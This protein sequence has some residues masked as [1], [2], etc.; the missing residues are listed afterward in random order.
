MIE[1]QEL[2]EFAQVARQLARMK[3]PIAIKVN[4]ISPQGLLATMP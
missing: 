3:L 1:F 4:Q 2:C